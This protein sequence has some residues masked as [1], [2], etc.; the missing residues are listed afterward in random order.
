MESC[1]TKTVGICI[2]YRR[3]VGAELRAAAPF[4]YGKISVIEAGDALFLG[5]GRIHNCSKYV[6][7]KVR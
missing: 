5:G 7:F 2:E 6:D 1:T 4:I 3:F